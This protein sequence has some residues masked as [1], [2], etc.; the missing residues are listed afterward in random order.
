M[1]L[2]LWRVVGFLYVGS[3][4][5]TCNLTDMRQKALACFGLHVGMVPKAYQHALALGVV[6]LLVSNGTGGWCTYWDPHVAV[7]G[8]LS[9]CICGHGW[10]VVWLSAAV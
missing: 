8:H 10:R 6:C 3:C 5:H 2:Y 1:N 9:K 7:H 4:R